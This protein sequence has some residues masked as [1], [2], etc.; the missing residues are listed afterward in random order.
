MHICL[1]NSR[2]PSSV[3]LAPVQLEQLWKVGK[4]A[5]R[6]T[7]TLAH[8][9]AGWEVRL[10]SDFGPVRIDRVPFRGSGVALADVRL[11][12]LEQDGWH[13]RSLQTDERLDLPS[14]HGLK[15]A[16]DKGMNAVCF[17][18]N[19]LLQLLEP[20]ARGHKEVATQWP[21]RWFDALFVQAQY[22]FHRTFWDLQRAAEHV[23]RIS[24]KLGTLSAD[25]DTWTH[26]DFVTFSEANQDLPLFFDLILYYWR[27]QAD[28][29]ANM[30]PHFYGSRGRKESIPRDSFRRQRTWFTSKRRPFDAAYAAILENHTGWFEFLAGADPS[31]KGVRDALA[32]NRATFQFSV[33]HWRDGTPASV[34]AALIG[35][36]GFLQDDLVPSV[37]RAMR[38][39]CLYLDYMV[40]HFARIIDE[41]VG[42]P[43][44]NKA[45]AE[46]ATYHEPGA[47]K[48]VWLL[49]VIDPERL[50]F[51]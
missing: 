10:Q 29:L 44:A 24:E 16:P 48:S 36:S 49:P 37:R 22:K 3:T 9:S 23:G 47:L 34:S 45:I 42:S 27:I 17:G 35:D 15:T 11:R 41:Q 4:G 51:A 33:N 30:T 25:G 12:E 32:H 14:W 31:D 43:V 8:T 28:C 21:D 46:A 1:L 50:P 19:G 2:D 13:P 6:I 26:A 7:C 40:V 39:Y 38:E 18:I 5:R 20:Y